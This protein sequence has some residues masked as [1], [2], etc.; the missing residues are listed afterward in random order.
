MESSS[1]GF[2][3]LLAARILFAVEDGFE[4][5]AKGE[6]DGDTFMFETL[7]QG[8]QQVRFQMSTG[9]G[10]SPGSWVAFNPQ[11]EPPAGFQN[12]MGF[13]FQFSSFSP[14]FLTVDVL[15]DGVE[16]LVFELI[17]QADADRDGDVD[18]EDLNSWLASFGNGLGGDFD[19]NGRTDGGD[20]L[21]WQRQL[22]GPMGFAT[23]P[24]PSAL[25]LVVGSAGL[26]LLR[27]QFG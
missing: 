24:E 19:Q 9:S 10:G 14:A 15:D 6:P 20:F 7:G 21:L 8:L 2:I 12:A 27:R 18:G 26:F 1:L 3:R 25:L 23:V 17:A 13:D 5:I 11:P 16:P 22:T 4:I